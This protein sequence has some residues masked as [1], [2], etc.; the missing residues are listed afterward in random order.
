MLDRLSR[1]EFFEELRVLE[2]RNLRCVRVKPR[3]I[4]VPCYGKVFHPEDCPATSFMKFLFTDIPRLSKEVD[5]CSRDALQVICLMYESEAGKIFVSW[6]DEALY[7][8]ARL[9]DNEN[10]DRIFSYLKGLKN[11]GYYRL[12]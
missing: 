7:G 10:E 1:F 3:M 11:M 12:R 2:E 4:D 5:D 9:I 8:F 6:S